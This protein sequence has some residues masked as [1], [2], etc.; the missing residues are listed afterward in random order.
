MHTLQTVLNCRRQPLEI[1]TFFKVV[2]PWSNPTLP[3]I[4]EPQ[5]HS[6]DALHMRKSYIYS[7][8]SRAHL[9]VTTDIVSSKE[10]DLSFTVWA[11]N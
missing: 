4:Y 3:H 11:T 6:R 9:A 7:G 5:N 10:A 1:P 2:K 8:R